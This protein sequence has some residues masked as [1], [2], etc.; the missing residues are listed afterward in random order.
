MD[1]PEPLEQFPTDWQRALAI[2]AHPDDLEYGM[3]SAIARWTSEGREVAYVL[4]TSGEAGIDGIAP[5]DCGPLREAEERASAAVVGVSSVEFLGHRDGVVEY[6][7]PLRRDLAR[8][9]RSHRPELVVTANRHLHWPGGG[10]FNM[11]DHRHVGLAC[12]DAARDAA[13][14][15]IFPELLDEGAAPWNGARWVAF[16]GSPEATHAVDV[17]GFLAKGIESLE[18]HEA[19]LRGLGGDFPAPTEFLT[20]IAEATGPRLG[21]RHAVAFEVIAI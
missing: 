19:Y 7:L 4:V 21:V 1:A 16:G 6:G 20:S 3:A 15:W 12:L 13:N 5:E 8:A 9:I 11:A 10:G 2:V 14:R 18:A 17:T